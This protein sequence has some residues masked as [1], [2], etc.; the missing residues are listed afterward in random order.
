MEKG[1]Q[2]PRLLLKCGC[3]D[4]KLEVYYGG[5]SLEINGV[6]GAV[7]DWRG[8]IEPLLRGSRRR[9]DVTKKGCQ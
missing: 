8:L 6:H 9:G 3:C 7:Q 2:S 5:D 4:Q 1:K